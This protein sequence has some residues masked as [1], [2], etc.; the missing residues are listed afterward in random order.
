MIESD[1]SLAGP[2]A[3]LLLRPRRAMTAPQ[4]RALFAVLAASIAAVATVNYGLGNVFAPLFAVADV[5]F[6]AAVLRQVWRQGDRQER[7]VVTGR[8]LEVRRPAQAAPVFS[9]HPAW[10]TLARVR[11]RGQARVLLRSMGREVEIGAFLAEAERLELAQ[12]LEILLDR[13]RL[14]VR[15]TDNQS[16]STQ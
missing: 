5:L 10:V 3:Q 4:F 13:A 7:I 8:V 11:E 16:R 2:E 1:P 14:P 6:V 15:D 9:A 12:R